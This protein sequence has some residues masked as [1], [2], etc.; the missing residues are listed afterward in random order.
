MSADRPY[1]APVIWR[2]GGDRDD[3]NGGGCGCAVVAAAV[4][5][6]TVTVMVT[7]AGNK[8]Y[9][10]FLTPEANNPRRS[11]AGA[12]DRKHTSVAGR[13]LKFPPADPA[14]STGERIPH[15]GVRDPTTPLATYHRRE[16]PLTLLRSAPSVL[17][18]SLETVTVTLY[19]PL[20]I[21]RSSPFPPS[22]HPSLRPS[23][24]PRRSATRALAPTRP[25]T[26]S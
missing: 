13:V 2:G 18:P 16:H 14:S 20:P 4:I 21:P 17:Q 15:T 24:L 19:E 5:V 12:S 22:P 3:S 26:R 6:T 8:S 23:F 7:T 25:P 11:S 9:K 1:Q 10:E